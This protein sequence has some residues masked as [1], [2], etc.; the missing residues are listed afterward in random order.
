M[1]FPDRPWYKVGMD[2]FY[3]PHNYILIVD[4]YSRYIEVSQLT[5]EWLI[6]SN[7]ILYNH[8]IK[9]WV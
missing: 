8:T 2:M 9:L 6:P 5:K 1:L 7:A 4:Y 3:W